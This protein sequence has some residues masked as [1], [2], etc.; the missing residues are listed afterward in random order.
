MCSLID[1]ARPKQSCAWNYVELSVLEDEQLRFPWRFEKR[2]KMWT[3][4]SFEQ[5]CQRGWG[6]SQMPYLS[7]A[8]AEKGKAG[9][10]G[11][12]F[13]SMLWF[14][15]QESVEETL[16]SLLLSL[17]LSSP[18]VSWHCKLWR[19]VSSLGRPLAVIFTATCVAEKRWRRPQNGRKSHNL[20][21][22]SLGF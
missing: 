21:I 20:H 2:Q 10:K 18:L 5:P 22:H 14:Y 11:E 15:R 1:P 12:T 13:P 8:N 19:P 17:H 6:R 7:K 16:S 4:C 3:S 9:L